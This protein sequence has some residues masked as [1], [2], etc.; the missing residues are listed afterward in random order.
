MSSN[1]GCNISLIGFWQT[2]NG[3]GSTLF[4]QEDQVISK[5]R[6]EE[7]V[8]YM[9]SCPEN[10][11]YGSIYNKEISV[12]FLLQDESTLFVTDPQRGQVEYTKIPNYTPNP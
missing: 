10:S 7:G 1:N 8:L 12:Q 11:M 6:G 9:Y 5:N 3:N 2:A 4:F